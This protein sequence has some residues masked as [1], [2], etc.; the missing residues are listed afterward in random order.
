MEEME[1][2]VTALRGFLMHECHVIS[3][4]EIPSEINLVLNASKS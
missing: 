4:H 1:A 2:Q 3:E